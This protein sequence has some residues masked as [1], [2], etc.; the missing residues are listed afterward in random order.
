MALVKYKNQIEY[1]FIIWMNNYPESCHWA[2]DERFYCFVKNVCRYHR[3]K[4]WEDSDF[5][6]KKIIERIPNFDFNKLKNIIELYR[7]LLDFYK[8]RHLPGSWF[9]DP[10]VEAPDGYYIERGVK[11]GKLYEKEKLKEEYLKN[12]N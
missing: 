12:N 10:D 7:C 2:D 8:A 3:A 11:N 4:K 1:S 6:K 5:L 9:S